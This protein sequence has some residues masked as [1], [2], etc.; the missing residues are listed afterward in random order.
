MIISHQ[1]QSVVV[2]EHALLVAYARFGEQVGLISAVQQ[3]LGA[4][5]A[6][7]DQLAKSSE[8]ET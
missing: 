7:A 5:H 1:N 2:T 8:A 4:I 3:V 6:R